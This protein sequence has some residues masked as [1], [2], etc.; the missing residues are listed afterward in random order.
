MTCYFMDSSALVKRY[1]H[2]VG[3]SWTRQLIDPAAGN[4]ILVS[5][6]SRVEVAAALAAKHRAPQGI[7]EGQRNAAVALLLRHCGAEYQ[8]V[9][10]NAAVLDRA[11]TLTQNHRLRGY[12]AIQLSSALTANDALL[13]Q[14]QAGLVFVSADADLVLAASAEGLSADNP[15]AHP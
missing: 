15:L 8:L 11:V 7:S 9:A 14:G 6:V 3:A 4:A 5:E 1:V 10:I 13:A 2:E 12:D